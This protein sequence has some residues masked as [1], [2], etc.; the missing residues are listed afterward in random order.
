MRHVYKLEIPFA[1]RFALSMSEVAQVTGLSREVIDELR[2]TGQLQ[3]VEVG[4][5]HIATIPAIAR[6]LN[7]TREEL[8][9]LHARPM[10]PT[11][12]IGKVA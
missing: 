12:T 9:G 5:H 1:D 11:L 4:H 2:K 6:L 10:A 8:L 7:V 3:T